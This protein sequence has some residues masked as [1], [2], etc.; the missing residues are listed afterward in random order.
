MAGSAGHLSL[1]VEEMMCSFQGTGGS[2]SSFILLE[3]LR[4]LWKKL[5]LIVPSRAK[6]PLNFQYF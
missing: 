4:D 1:L 5:V 6:D 2:A 3:Q